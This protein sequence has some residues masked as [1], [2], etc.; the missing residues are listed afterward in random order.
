VTFYAL[1]P[2]LFRSW[3]LVLLVFLGAM[4]ARYYVVYLQGYSVQSSPSVYHAFPMLVGFFML[5][6]L[7]KRVYEKWTHRHPRLLTLSGLALAVAIVPLDLNR[8]QFDGKGFYLALG[9]LAL[10]LPLLFDRTKD[11]RIS[12]WLGDVSYPLYLLHM[13]LIIAFGS[14]FVLQLDGHPVLAG[15][16]SGLA[17]VAVCILA[18]AVVHAYVELPVGRFLKSHVRPRTRKVT[19]SEPR[20][21]EAPASAAAEATTGAG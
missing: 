2:F 6:Y 14:L 17:F 4:A 9:L 8:S 20:L 11:S 16:L 12:N 18:S 10:V 21:G 3:K 13:P 1:A 5:G 7:A 19:R 15:T